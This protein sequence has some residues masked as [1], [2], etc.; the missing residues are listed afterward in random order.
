VAQRASRQHISRKDLKKD[1]FRETLTHGAE[2]VRLHQQAVS[3]VVIAAVVIAAAVL[4]WR[5]YAQHKTAQASAALADAMKIYEA[6]VRSAGEPAP[7]EVNGP[8]YT[9]ETKKYQDAA[10]KFEA[11]ASAYGRTRPGLEARYYAAV[12]YQQLGRYDLAKKNLNTVESSG[13][14]DMAALARFQ[15]AGLDA[16]SGNSQQA[17]ALYNQLLNSNSVLVPKP[18][19]MLSLAEL[20]RT[21]NPAEATKL[22]NQV[23]AQYPNTPAAEE[24]EKRLEMPSS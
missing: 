24:A 6:P 12:C 10:A 18:L 14:A 13:D 8:S 17:I 9:D 11:V 15:L 22:L 5:F 16:V 3:T 21:S 2:A 1:E 19:V 20:Y 7:A 23:K 4:G